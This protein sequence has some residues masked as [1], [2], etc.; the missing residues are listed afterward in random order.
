MGYLV[1]IAVGTVGKGVG[2]VVMRGVGVHT[3]RPHLV[4]NCRKVGGLRYP[5]VPL[6]YPVNLSINLEGSTC[7]LAIVAMTESTSFVSPE[8]TIILMSMP[9]ISL[10]SI[11]SQ[12][13]KLQPPLGHCEPSVHACSYESRASDRLPSPILSTRISVMFT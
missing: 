4:W 9:R 11:G 2:E 13:P 5:T 3:P 7:K 6:R 1:G 10:S 8:A 12:V